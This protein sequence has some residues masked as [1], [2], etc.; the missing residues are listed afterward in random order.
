VGLVAYLLFFLAGLGF[1]WAAPG[2]L[3]WVPL[4]FPVLLFLV[5]LLTSGFGIWPVVKLLIA[6]IVTAAGVIVG[7]M[8]DER[9]S[10]GEAS[11]A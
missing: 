5:A 6:L 10:E 9:G 2:R 3:K 1:G 4:I 8:L 11:A 7:R